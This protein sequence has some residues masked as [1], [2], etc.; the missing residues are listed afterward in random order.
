MLQKIKLWWNIIRPYSLFASACPVLVGLLV[1]N[2]TSFLTA[3]ITLFCA[4][5]LQVL[6]NL[7]ND[8]YDFER[9]TDDDRTGSPR[10]LAE[11]LVSAKQMLHAIYVTVFLCVISGAYLV[12]VGGWV[13]LIVGVLALLFAWLYTATDYSLAYLGLG[14]IFVFLFYG[15]IAGC[16]TAYL[17]THDIDTLWQAFYA[18]GVNGL[19]SMCLLAINNIRDRENDAK[20]NKR[21]FAVR[22]GHKMAIFGMFVVVLLQPIFAYLAFGWSVVLL[23]FFPS[24]VLFITVFRTTEAGV[25]NRCMLWTGFTNVFYV[26]L[27]AIEKFCFL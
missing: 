26:L 25:Y 19:I 10:L 21:T 24:I 9:G 3:F 23:I 11:G 7:V 22:F 1:A 12:L 27:V 2:I 18:G 8:Y 17:Q 5:C 6:S 16:G 13:I 15:V 4:I 14:D 20:F